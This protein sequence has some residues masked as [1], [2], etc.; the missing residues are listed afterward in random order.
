MRLVI[1]IVASVLILGACGGE[2]TSTS[3][4]SEPSTTTA[5]DRTTTSTTAEPPAA[6]VVLAELN[7]ID[8]SVSGGSEALTDGSILVTDAFGFAE[9]T[10]FDESI[11]R[12]DALTT[13]E[14]IEL[15]EASGES[16][17][18]L[19]MDSGRTWHRVEPLSD[20]SVYEVA[21]P[22]ATVVVR[23]TTFFISC[24]SAT[25]CIFSVIEGLLELVLPSGEVL[26]VEAPTE[27]TISDGESVKQ[28][29]SNDAAQGDSWLFSNGIRDEELGFESPAQLFEE[30]GVAFASVWGRFAT[31]GEL[32]RFECDGLACD[33]VLQATNAHLRGDYQFTVE[34]DQG[35]C[36]AIAGTGFGQSTTLD[37]ESGETTT[38][39]VP[40]IFDGSVYRWELDASTFL[41]GDTAG[42]EYGE[43]T[44]HFEWEFTPTAA[45]IRRGRYVVTEGTLLITTI[46]ASTDPVPSQCANNALTYSHDQVH[47]ATRRG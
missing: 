36:G 4:S 11:T 39:N 47:L 9:V 32:M 37:P 27:I 17:I 18:R 41:C 38:K 45:E 20:N 19:A 14:L 35:S 28:P 40:L 34:C 24:P 7:T 8:G 16:L 12:L 42:N 26:T 46:G 22:V 2:S 13:L 31:S 23:G 10:Y 15:S 21:T 25:L 6:P 33:A 43:L 29:L 5:S 30:F 44:A 1:A 3:T